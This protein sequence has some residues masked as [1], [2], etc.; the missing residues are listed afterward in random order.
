MKT[1]KNDLKRHIPN[2]NWSIKEEEAMHFA[3]IIW[4]KSRINAASLIGR[5]ER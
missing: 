4:L 3:L 1:N 5:E 2:E